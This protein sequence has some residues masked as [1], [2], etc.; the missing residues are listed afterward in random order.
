MAVGGLSYLNASRLQALRHRKLILFPD[1]GA[2]ATWHKKALALSHIAP[3]AV[4]DLLESQEVEE[5]S[6]LADFLV[7][8][9]LKEVSSR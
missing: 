6:D 9:S 2:Y 7:P 4:S 5:G 8:Y 1:K 3:I